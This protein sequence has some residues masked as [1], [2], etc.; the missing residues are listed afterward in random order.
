VYGVLNYL[1]A[2]IDKSLIYA[3]LDNEATREVFTSSDGYDYQGGS[4]VLQVLGYFSI[5]GLLRVHILLGDY[6]GGLKV[7]EP[8]DISRPGVFTKVSGC[9]ITTMYYA[10]FAYLMIRR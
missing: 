5:V 10:G 1:Q 4:N 8:L 9:H 6:H 3:L 7:L 2:L